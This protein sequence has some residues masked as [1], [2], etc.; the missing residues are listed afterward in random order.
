VPGI[1]RY[2]VACEY[3]HLD[4]TLVFNKW[5]LADEEALALVDL[6]EKA[7]Y[8]VLKTRAIEDPED[9]RSQVMGLDFS[10]L[11]VLGPSG[12]GKSSITN[13]ILPDHGAATGEVNDVTGKGRQTTTHI[14]LVRLGQGRY[15][16]D[17]PGLGHLTML[18]IEPHN[19]KN[20]YREL[21]ALASSCRYAN[22]LHIDE[23]DCAV[24][25]EL[26]SAVSEQR[27]R[28]Y[29]DFVTDL[30]IEYERSKVKG[31]KR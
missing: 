11:Y 17:T 28:S 22:C 24:K 7:G 8:K 25:A 23:P 16:A 19:L 15:L 31:K 18:G 4:V 3:Q 6:Y 5:D 10:K 27:Y 9:T 2:I 30:A 12:V 20:L 1:D 26:G 29:C 14:E 13:A 21:Y